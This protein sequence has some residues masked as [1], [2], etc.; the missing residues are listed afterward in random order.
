MP[1][2]KKEEAEFTLPEK[3]C[4]RR[5]DENFDIINK[6]FNENE[7][8]A[9]KGLYDRSG[10]LCSPCTDKNGVFYHKPQGY[11]EITFDQF[12]KYIMKEPRTCMAVIAFVLNKDLPDCKSGT[13]SLRIVNDKV[14]FPSTQDLDDDTIIDENIYSLELCKKETDWFYPIC[15]IGYEVGD[16]II[17]PQYRITK[18]T[19][20]DGK[21]VFVDKESFEF[22][23][24]ASFSCESIIGERVK[25]AT[26]EEIESYFS[27]VIEGHRAVVSGDNKIMFGCYK[28]TKEQL[29]AYAHLL[30]Q[31][32]GLASIYVKEYKITFEVLQKLI[33]LLAWKQK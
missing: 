32:G 8:G 28:F 1:D 21:E 30:S 26:N 33:N 3:W 13:K 23:G 10:F 16:F 5:N 6:W 14:Y 17:D 22:T 24:F 31:E 7:S 12:Q 25:K 4:V 2:N 20:I 29:R 11:T 9:Y 18:I 19:K 15:E 27:I